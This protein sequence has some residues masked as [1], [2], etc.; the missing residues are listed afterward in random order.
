MQRRLGAG[1]VKGAAHHFA[2]NGDHA[3]AGFREAG[4]ELLKAGPEL[5]RIEQPEHPTERVVARQPFF[6]FQVPAQE[7]LLGLGKHRRLA[8]AQDRAQRDEQ[9][10][11]QIVQSGVARARIVHPQQSCQELSKCDSPGRAD[12]DTTLVNAA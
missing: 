5:I 9:Y 7:P 1:G 8:A 4:H 12:V 2:I 10:L 3:L 6:Q 11:V